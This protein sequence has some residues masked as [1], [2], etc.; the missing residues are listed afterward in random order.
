MVHLPTS[1]AKMSF[2]LLPLNPCPLATPWMLRSKCGPLGAPLPV[3]VVPARALGIASV[4]AA[5]SAV[6][7]PMTKRLI[8]SSWKM[9]RSRPPAGTNIVAMDRRAASATYGSIEPSRC[10]A[11]Q[12]NS[13]IRTD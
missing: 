10:S 13:L 1:E 12:A 7:K 11:D 5:S 4:T 2:W 8:V 6:V 9:V 3:L